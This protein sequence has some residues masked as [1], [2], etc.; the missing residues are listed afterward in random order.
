M[1]SYEDLR[2]DLQWLRSKLMNLSGGNG[3]WALVKLRT[4]EQAIDDLATLVPIGRMY[5][6]A[7]DT[8]LDVDPDHEMLIV[9]KAIAVAAVREAVER[10][11]A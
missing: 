1:S 11:E 7:L 4:I 9:P 2:A 3:T 10:S 5:L 6:D 8:A